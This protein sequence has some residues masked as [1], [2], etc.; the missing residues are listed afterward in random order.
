MGQEHVGEGGLLEHGGEVEGRGAGA[1]AGVGVG[2]TGEQGRELFNNTAEFALTDSP[3]PGYGQSYNPEAAYYGEDG[4]I[5]HIKDIGQNTQAVFKSNA[6][7][8]SGDRRDVSLVLLRADPVAIYD[9]MNPQTLESWTYG[10][11][12]IRAR[13]P[14][15]RGT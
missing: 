3:R 15:G 12:E 4:L 2:A 7:D 5:T 11:F 13:V 10:R 8:P 14:A 1:V 9:L 6:L